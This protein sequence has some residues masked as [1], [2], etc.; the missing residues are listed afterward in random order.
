MPN[1]YEYMYTRNRIVACQATSNKAKCLESGNK[2][3]N[4][5]TL[6]DS[7]SVLFNAPQ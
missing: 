6:S 7:V 2:N 3:T 1:Y 4:M 5:A